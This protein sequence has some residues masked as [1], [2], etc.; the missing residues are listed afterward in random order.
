MSCF[1]YIAVH[2]STYWTRIPVLAYTCTY[3]YIPVHTLQQ[4][5]R[6]PAALAARHRRVQ[7]IV[8]SA[9]RRHCAQPDYR[10]GDEHVFNDPALNATLLHYLLGPASILSHY[11]AQHLIS[12]SAPDYLE[13]RVHEI[14][15][16]QSRS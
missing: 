4:I 8:A 5:K 12:L 13:T 14:A 3:R 9:S 11:Q 7:L 1:W 2:T 16:P 15:T 10:F 6:R